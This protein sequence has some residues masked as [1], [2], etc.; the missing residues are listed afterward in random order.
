MKAVK[1]WVPNLDRL[2]KPNIH[3]SYGVRSTNTATLRCYTL[4]SCFLVRR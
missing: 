2:D 3:I 1:L 4:Q